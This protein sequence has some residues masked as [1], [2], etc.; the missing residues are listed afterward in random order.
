MHAR[1][2]S[3]G[4]SLL[5]LSCHSGLG[6]PA[7]D[8]S[9]GCPDRPPSPRLVVHDPSGMI[10]AT[11]TTASISV[12]VTV[13]S[14]DSCDTVDCGGSAQA[15]A[16]RHVLTTADGASWTLFVFFPGMPADL[17]KVGDAL[18]LGVAVTFI[19]NNGAN[20]Y[21][22]YTI[23]LHQNGTLILFESD[24]V[25][26]L[27]ADGISGDSEDRLIC[28]DFCAGDYEASVT[29]G[30]QTAFPVVPGQSVLL[31]GLTVWLEQSTR[32]TGSCD[33]PSVF[34]LAGYRSP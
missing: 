24:H 16:R 17:I 30:T 34:E 18:D 31:G 28:S 25:S 19:V 32:G 12:P 8:A 33:S 3:L 14:I 15:G 10:P 27:A 26:D 4:L 1:A 20:A 29:V 11:S 5:L 13:A 22:R 2:L 9:G 6:A 21:D 23:S 7:P